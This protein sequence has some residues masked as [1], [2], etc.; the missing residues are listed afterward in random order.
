MPKAALTWAD[1]KSSNFP[2]WSRPSHLSLLCSMLTA[3]RRSST[4]PPDSLHREANGFRHALW[5][6][7]SIRLRWANDSADTCRRSLTGCSTIS[8][9]PFSSVGGGS[10]VRRSYGRCVSRHSRSIKF[11]VIRTVADDLNG[12]KRAR[13]TAGPRKPPFTPGWLQ[14][15]EWVDKR[16]S[17]FPATAVRDSCLALKNGVVDAQQTTLSR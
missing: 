5:R 3:T 9:F 8:S 15:P 2:S 7:S 14:R 13:M 4:Q 10:K 1:S 11:A 17:R 12:G 16:H 6:A